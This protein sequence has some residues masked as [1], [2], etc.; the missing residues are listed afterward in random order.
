MIIKNM[1]ELATTELRKDVLS[2]I[3]AGVER[4]LPSTIMKS[5]VKYDL[6][7]RILTVGDYAYP[8]SRGR[9]FVIG[10]G[11][12]AGIMAETLE[13]IVTPANITAGIVACKSSDY[14]T[15]KITV[16]E[17]GHPVPD[18][19]GLDGVNK[20]LALRERYSINGNDL[21]I[22]LISG[23]S[24]ALMPCPVDGVRLEDK[25]GIT[26]LLLGSGASI[27]EI[28]VVRKHL[29]KT[30]GGGL[31]HSYSPA[32]VVSLILSDVIGND[33]DVIASGQTCPDPST[34]SDAYRVLEEYDLLS[35]A[36]KG[37]IDFLARGC[38][39]QVEETPK[40]TGNCINHI[41]GDNTLAL[42]AMFQKA[43]ELGLGPYIVT[44]G[45]KGDTATMAR[46]RAAEIL[47]HKY[48]G[49][50]VVLIGGETTSVLPKVAGKGG[51][52]QHYA[53]VSMLAMKRHTG[54]WVSASIGTDGSDFLPDVAGAIVDS[55]S[56]ARAKARGID[57]E[58]YVRQYD[59]NTLLNRIGESLIV[60]GNTGTNVGDLIVYAFRNMVELPETP[61][62]SGMA[63]R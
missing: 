28:N 47:S 9:V 23:G 20:M 37:I 39:G 30:K 8:L 40:S 55:G 4:V 45:Q 59:S 35:R 62:S 7:G 6:T 34:F 18:Q 19:R 11:K 13:R 42:Q 53:A 3:E 17:A 33:L 1:Q 48:T 51:R 12:A 61:S 60:T 44:A 46:L 57:V 32:A 21:V 49:Y 29:S 50:D 41:M 16:V 10:G 52:N 2:L 63:L 31:G 25:Q 24:S 36:P 27:H 38:Q 56:L 58:S 15:S 43:K 26:R 14:K 54:E 5:V 22:C